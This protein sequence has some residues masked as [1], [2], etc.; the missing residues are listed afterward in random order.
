MR[1][2]TDYVNPIQL[3]HT[4]SGLGPG[5]CNCTYAL[6][7]IGFN[8]LIF[9]FLD[10]A[11]DYLIW[12]VSNILAAIA[13][14]ILL[15]AR[16]RR[17]FRHPISNYELETLLSKAKDRLQI[18]Q[19]IELWLT[20]DDGFVL[21]NTTNLLF[22]CII[23]S[24]SVITRLLEKPTLGEIIVADE[25]FQIENGP[26]KFQF[27]WDFMHYSFFSTAT[28][29]LQES[30]LQLLLPVG[31]FIIQTGILLLALALFT[32]TIYSR[33]PT[34]S[35]NIE[36]VYGIT[37]LDA[38]NE[39]FGEVDR[40][41]FPLLRSSSKPR[42]TESSEFRLGMLP[43]P[44]VISAICG[45]VTYIIFSTI[46]SVV[47]EGMPYVVV[48][49][50]I[51]FATI[52]FSF[53]FEIIN[54]I[55]YENAGTHRP[56]QIPSF[57]DEQT[58]SLAE[59]F[60]EIPQ[61][62]DLLV[63]KRKTWDNRLVM[64]LGSEQDPLHNSGRISDVVLKHLD[65]EELFVYALAE[66]ERSNARNADNKWF[67]RFIGI[68]SLLI[69]LFGFFTVITI[70][71]S[72]FEVVMLLIFLYVGFLFASIAIMTMRTNSKLQRVDVE[73]L[74]EY[75]SLYSIIEKLQDKGNGFEVKQHKERIEYLARFNR[76]QSQIKKA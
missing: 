12:I 64:T 72:V 61:Y 4:I 17:K 62:A 31:V 45:F 70:P 55:K 48:P 14:H 60:H 29:F 8:T 52:G 9:F 54:P 10:P 15:L 11:T 50:S 27:V 65:P 67:G 22:S 2:E 42:M 44:L 59:L 30:L 76:T 35:L 71:Q 28:Y 58:T 40:G 21:V 49:L 53:S 66:I 41:F 20:D 34:I 3:K 18:P 43:A 19:N 38:E 6:L 1:E 36:A 73:I 68:I 46:L 25:V 74:K 39:I 5:L 7:A 33:R 69:F 24:N 23:M 51:L 63:L 57:E 32:F 47:S 56:T 13:F 75:P 26:R 37:R 16:K